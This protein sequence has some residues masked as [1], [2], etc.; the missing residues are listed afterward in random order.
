MDPSISNKIKITHEMRLFIQECADE[1]VGANVA[2]KLLRRRHP[3]KEFNKDEI[4]RIY[5]SYKLPT[6][7]DGFSEAQ[8]LLNFLDKY[9]H[10][11]TDGEG[12]FYQHE[13]DS[14]QR[15]TRVFWMDPNQ[16]ALF[17][18][19]NDVVVHDTTFKTNRFEMPLHCFVVVDS[20][21]KTRL[22]ASALTLGQKE[23]DHAWVLESLK[24]SVGVFPKVLLVDNDAAM[25]AAIA[26]SAESTQVVNCIWHINKNIRSKLVSILGRE[27]WLQ[28]KAKFYTTR[29]TITPR[30]FQVQWESLMM[31]FGAA[32]AIHNA[33][34]SDGDGND[35]S[36]DDGD[37]ADDDEGS[38]EEQTNPRGSASKIR[39]YLQRLYKRRQYWG[40][41]W[42]HTTFTAGMRSTQRVEKTNHLI[43]VALNNRKSLAELFDAI[44]VVVKKELFSAEQLK[45]HTKSRG[46]NDKLSIGAS[47]VF[48]SMIELNAKYLSIYAQKQLNIEMEYSLACDSEVS[49]YD[50]VTR[51]HCI[52]EVNIFICFVLCTEK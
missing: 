5:K 51:R 37:V 49:S 21:N 15:L 16:R 3:G 20:E 8:Q 18:R 2:L 28:F 19:Y 46:R 38:A 35:Q 7:V 6:E 24:A 13:V 36:D 33:E 40:G 42:V 52:D 47:R 50:D 4:G 43:K 23:S 32:R 17:R 44:N 30:E 45:S 25:D 26:N 10:V 11:D 34:I 9:P 31:E 48:K 39:V 29:D 1:R 22:V 12:W 14:E 41:P 27:R